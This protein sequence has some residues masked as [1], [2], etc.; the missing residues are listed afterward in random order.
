MDFFADV[1]LSAKSAKI[2]SHENSP[3]YGSRV[4]CLSVADVVQLVDPCVQLV[5]P[6]VQLVSDTY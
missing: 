1:R 4:I 6:T 2:L 5:S 3:L